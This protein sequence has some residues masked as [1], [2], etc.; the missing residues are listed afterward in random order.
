MYAT[1]VDNEN[2]TWK[3][4]DVVKAFEGPFGW[5]VILG[6]QVHPTWTEAILARPMI[7]AHYY[8]VPVASPLLSMEQYSINTRDLER[9]K[10][11]YRSALIGSDFALADL[12]PSN[13]LDWGEGKDGS[14]AR[15]LWSR[16]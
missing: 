10:E 4:G 14:G 2:G 11:G 7:H 16:E 6:F 12:E 1:R 8:G 5:A 15:E 3:I 9:P 13:R